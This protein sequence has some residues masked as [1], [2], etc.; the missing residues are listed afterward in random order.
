MGRIEKSLAY[1]LMHGSNESDNSS[2]TEEQVELIC[3]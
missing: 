1:L 2:K 3:S